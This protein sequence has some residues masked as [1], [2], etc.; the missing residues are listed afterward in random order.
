MFHL[1]LGIPWLFVLIRFIEPLPWLWSAKILLASVL[2]IASQH[3]LIYR[4]SSGS[5]F[6][7]EFPRPLII[8][9][10][11]LFGAILLLAVF[12]IA[13]DMVSIGISLFEGRF[14]SVP[15]EVRYVIGA[16]ALG[17]SAIGVS[18]AI[19][20]PSLKNLEVVIE[21]LPPAFDGYRLLQLT[22]L[23]I[24][25]LFPVRWTAAVVSRANA[26]DAD[27]IVVT[28]D[29]IDGSVNNRRADVEPL[30]KL[31][32]RDGVYAIPGNHE[33]FF[34]YRDWMIH[35]ESI[36][37]RMLEN[38]HVVIKRGDD[39]IVV[40]GVTDLSAVEHG[41]LAPDLSSAISGASRGAPIILLDHQPMHAAHA[42]EA[43]VKLQLS[44][45]TH[46][47][48]ILGL[49]RFVAR[50][51][52]GFV[53]GRYDVDGMQ[54]YVNNGTAIWPGFALRLGRSSELTVITLRADTA[55]S[56]S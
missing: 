45:H 22:D 17:L 56:S 16:A 11:L 46:G 51:N 47:G 1:I 2:L 27:L 35:L 5:I 8:V 10:N 40:A 12:Q 48:M 55:P 41:E 13:L 50:S 29:F 7:P 42:A 31:R 30:T 43:G 21:G 3:L 6:A 26:L 23:H 18:Q 34:S 37:M 25:R 36:G 28:G 14:Q 24:S 39:E 4:M 33:Y 54:L 9:F 38:S 52:N 20:I 32:A 19:G 15:A 49:D 53:S 44:G